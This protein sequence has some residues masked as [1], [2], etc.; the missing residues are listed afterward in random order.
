MPHRGRAPV[1]VVDSRD[2]AP[3]PS[4]AMK[5]HTC[6][7]R[8]HG[9]TTPLIQH[10]CGL[11]AKALDDAGVAY[12][13]QVAGGVKALGFTRRG[14]RDHIRALTGQEDVPVLELDDGSAIAGTDAIVAWAAERR[15]G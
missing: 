3:L 5:L 11:A 6:P 7:A 10:P 12:E 14:K 8:K 4:P 2:G 15:A 13:L 1:A 9:A